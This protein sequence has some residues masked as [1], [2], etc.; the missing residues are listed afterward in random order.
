[1]YDYV[2]ITHIYYLAFQKKKK[3]RDSWYVSLLKPES[4]KKKKK[5]NFPHF[6]I[7]RIKHEFTSIFPLLKHK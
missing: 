1:M 5:S 2:Y 4:Q 7:L 6:N 3:V